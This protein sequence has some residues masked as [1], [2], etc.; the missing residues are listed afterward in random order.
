MG[1]RLALY[2]GVLEER[3]KMHTL[4]LFSISLDNEDLEMSGWL[5]DIA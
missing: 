1:W 4:Y 2:Q 5:L 3:E